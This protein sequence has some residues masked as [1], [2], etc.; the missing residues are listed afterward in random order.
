M[1]ATPENHGPGPW[2]NYFTSNCVRGQ[3]HAG[4]YIVISNG[5]AI[6]FVASHYR[7][8]NMWPEWV[9]LISCEVTDEI[10]SRNTASHGVILCVWQKYRDLKHAG[11]RAKI[12]PILHASSWPPLGIAFLSLVGLLHI[13]ALPLIQF[14]SIFRVM[15]RISLTNVYM[16]TTI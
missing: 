15:Q 14:K 3:A 9:Q 7:R 11:H 8:A 16:I 4:I 6:F 1:P 5:F 2:R 13:T 12:M 10:A